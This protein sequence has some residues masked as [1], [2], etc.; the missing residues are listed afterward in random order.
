MHIKELTLQL[1]ETAQAEV[2]ALQQVISSL[3]SF[4]PREHIQVYVDH[5]RAQLV[6]EGRKTGTDP[7][8]TDISMD[9]SPITGDESLA[10]LPVLE[11]S[12]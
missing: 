8:L 7:N 1:L 4:S 3:D 2:R 6:A 5:V 9:A 12:S 11:V 10:N